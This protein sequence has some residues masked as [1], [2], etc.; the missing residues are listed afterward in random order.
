MLS[1]IVKKGCIILLLGVQKGAHLLHWEFKMHSSQTAHKT[2]S[3]TAVPANAPSRLDMIEKQISCVWKDRAS[4]TLS[5]RSDCKNQALY[6]QNSPCISQYQSLFLYVNIIFCQA[7]FY[8]HFYLYNHIVS[9]INN[10]SSDENIF[11]HFL[12]K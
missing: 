10:F 9:D 12:N 4:I 2:W 3:R 5:D 6:F 8:L 1:H 11:F 7:V